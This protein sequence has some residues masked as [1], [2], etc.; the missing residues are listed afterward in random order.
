MWKFEEI[1][2]S[3][4]NLTEGPVWDGSGLIFTDGK[5]NSL[6]RFDPAKNSIDIYF[7][8]TMGP[9]GLNF[10]S[11]TELFGCEQKGRKIVKY[12]NENIENSLEE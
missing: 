6:L 2:R 5:S 1:K 11:N 3:N 8:G 4:G 9:N 12:S 10:N 7:E